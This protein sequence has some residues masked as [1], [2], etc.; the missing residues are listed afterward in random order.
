MPHSIELLL[1]PFSLEALAAALGVAAT[2]DADA[3]PA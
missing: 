1:K 2:T 3:S